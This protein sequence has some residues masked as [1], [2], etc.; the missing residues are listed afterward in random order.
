MVITVQSFGLKPPHRLINVFDII[1][2]YL[3]VFPLNKEFGTELSALNCTIQNCDGRIFPIN[4]LDRT[5]IWQCDLCPKFVTHVQTVSVYKDV[6]S[7]MNTIDVF[8][9]NS[10]KTPLNTSNVRKDG[11]YV[12]DLKL[13][14]I[15]KST[16]KSNNG[17]LF[18]CW[19]NFGTPEP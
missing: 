19:R 10:L 6:E 8:C 11:P 5:S 15:W 17:Y 16:N 2:I 9:P 4:P 12:V 7:A 1:I 3:S 14:F 18:N 13:K